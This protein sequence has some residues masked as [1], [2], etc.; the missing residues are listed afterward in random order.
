MIIYVDENMPRHLAEG[1][2]ILQLP[3][4][5][6]LGVEVEVKYIPTAFGKGVKDDDWIPTIGKQEGCVITQDIHINRRKHEM[7][8]YREYGLG[9]FFLRGTSR[10]KGMSVWQMVEALASHWPDVVQA[11]INE[12]RPFGFEIKSKGKMKKIEL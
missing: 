5:L 1:F 2:H 4:G 8:L 3:E 11:S 9:V 10:K 7:Q 6:K 12:K